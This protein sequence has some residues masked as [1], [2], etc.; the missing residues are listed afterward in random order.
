ESRGRYWLSR[1][2]E[3]LGRDNKAVPTGLA[4][5]VFETQE[6]LARLRRAG[7]EERAALRSALEETHSLGAS[8]LAAARDGIAELLDTWPRSGGPNGDASGGASDATRALKERLSELAY[9]KTLDREIRAGLASAPALA[10]LEE[11]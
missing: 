7:G 10:S 11:R 9:L 6:T 3:D 1:L 2:G 4:D 8:R 5:L